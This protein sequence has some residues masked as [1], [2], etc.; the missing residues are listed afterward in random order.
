M[1]KEQIYENLQELLFSVLRN[2]QDCQEEE[3][4]LAAL[5]AQGGSGGTH[6]AALSVPSGLAAEQ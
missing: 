1:E 5:P 3:V 2:W 6:V 4:S